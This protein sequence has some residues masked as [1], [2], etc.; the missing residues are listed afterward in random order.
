MIGAVEVIWGMA[1]VAEGMDITG[2][3]LEGGL[4]EAGAVG[5]IW[6]MAGVTGD[7]K[8]T[9]SELDGGSCEE[10]FWEPGRLY[11]EWRL[12]LCIVRFRRVLAAGGPRGEE[13]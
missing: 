8:L 4:E 5:V 10:L 7:K 11:G 9:G 6:E 12:R 1:R 3:E 13:A 2:S